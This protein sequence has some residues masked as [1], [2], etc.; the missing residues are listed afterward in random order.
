MR[1]S[2]EEGIEDLSNGEEEGAPPKK[3][4]ATLGAFFSRVDGKPLSKPQLFSL[5]CPYCDFKVESETSPKQLPGGLQTH[6]RT[7]H[8]FEGEE[9]S[10]R[11]N[12]AISYVSRSIFD[13][14]PMETIR[15]R[16]N[17]NDVAMDID[18]SD[19]ENVSKEVKLRQSYTIKDKYRYLQFIDEA[20]IKIRNRL[21]PNDTYYSISLLEEVRRKTGVPI[22]TLKRWIAKKAIIKEKYNASKKVRLRR[23]LGSGRTPLFP[24]AEEIVA[25]LIR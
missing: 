10:A 23:R 24:K 3:R 18:N 15:E 12:A 25:N 20:E 22:G 14:L 2:R 13:Y 4:Q 7:K 8:P 1:R 19:S 11:Y 21:G 6:C 17:D 9:Y 16:D 5:A